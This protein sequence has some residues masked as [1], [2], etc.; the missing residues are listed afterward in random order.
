MQH[1]AYLI[2]DGMKNY[3]V[4]QSELS[5]ENLINN[6]NG[7]IIIMGERDKLSDYEYRSLMKKYNFLGNWVCLD[8]NII[9]DFME[10]FYS[11]VTTERVPDVFSMY[12]SF[13]FSHK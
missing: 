2:S 6:Y 3:S 9:Y 7:N 12:K 13:D 5:P 11:I 4:C 8:D 10:D 1:K